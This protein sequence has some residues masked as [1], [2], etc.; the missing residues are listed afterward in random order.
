MALLRKMTCNLRHHMG[1][2]HPVLG[3]SPPPSYIGLV[4]S[5]RPADLTVSLVYRALL[6]KETGGQHV[7][8]EEALC[9]ITHMW[10]VSS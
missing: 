8:S 6:C 2:R 9:S 4:W 5:K 3:E 1:L 10:L 7:L